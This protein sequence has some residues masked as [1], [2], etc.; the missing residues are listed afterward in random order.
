ME[1]IDSKRRIVYIDWLKA[2]AIFLVVLGH[3]CQNYGNNIEIAIDQYGIL[4]YH[5]PLFAILSGLFFNAKIDF[6]SFI[7]KKFMQLALPFLAWCIIVAI[8]IRSINET[9]L[10]ITEGYPIHF[11]SW[12][13]C[14]LMYI[15]DWGWWFLRDLF[16]S[17]VYAYISIRLFRRNVLL[18]VSLSIILLY[19]LSLSGIFPNKWNK[20]F[21]FIYPFFCTG[22]LMKEYK[23]FILRWTN[24]I[25]LISTIT[26]CVCMCFWQGYADTFYSMNTS[27]FEPKGY[28]GITGWMVPVKIVY[29]FITGISASLMLI[30]LARKFEKK[31]PTPPMLMSIGRNT[32]GIYILH[33][34]AFNIFTPPSSNILIENQII[35]FIACLA[36]SAI[37]VVA[38]DYIIKYTS[39]NQWLALLLWGKKQ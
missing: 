16:M 10:H 25:L 37:I 13:E 27:M 30:L 24:T 23:P 39:R 2:F 38:C 36:I 33:S 8:V 18:G 21:V 29:R 6:K 28:A 9:Y 11:K 5:M 31:L 3:I 14:L 12:I 19:A 7:S 20:E 17:F 34:F 22:I 32:L 26:F 4:P 35:S 15:I 1:T